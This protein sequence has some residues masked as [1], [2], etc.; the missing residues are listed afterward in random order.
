MGPGPRDLESRHPG[1][2]D[3]GP[4]QNLNL[5]PGTPSLKFKSGTPGPPSKFESGT[6]GPPGLSLMNSFFF[7]FTYLFLRLF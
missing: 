5:E 3:L 6:P 4:P 2:W 1:N 7:F